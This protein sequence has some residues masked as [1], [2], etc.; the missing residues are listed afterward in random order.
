MILPPN[1]PAWWR[2]GLGWALFVLGPGIGLL[3]GLAIGSVIW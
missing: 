1:P 2:N 3:L